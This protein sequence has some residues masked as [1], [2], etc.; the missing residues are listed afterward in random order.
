[1]RGDGNYFAAIDSQLGKDNGVGG[2]NHQTGGRKECQEC[3]HHLIA[4]KGLGIQTPLGIILLKQFLRQ[5]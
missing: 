5:W 3:F 1:M 4:V 2:A